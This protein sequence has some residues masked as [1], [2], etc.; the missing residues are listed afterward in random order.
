MAQR[1][2]VEIPAAQVVAARQAYH[3]AL[4][5]L[6]QASGEL[7]EIGRR[8]EG[9]SQLSKAHIEAGGLVSDVPVTIHLRELRADLD[10]ALTRFHDARMATRWQT[11]VLGAAEG[12]SLSEL[13]RQFGVS[14]QYVSKLLREQGSTVADQAR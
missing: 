8:I 7:A 6:E 14:R 5:E 2:L 3:D 12:T 13:A 10:A 11:I 1:P 4:D 9:T